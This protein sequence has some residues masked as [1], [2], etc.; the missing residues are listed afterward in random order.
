MKKFKFTLEKY[1]EMKEGEDSTLKRELS[2]VNAQIQQI[3][4]SI[5]EI[6]NREDDH[7]HEYDHKFR[8]GVSGWQLHEYSQYMGYLRQSKLDYID[9]LN[10]LMEKSDKY[11]ER[12]IVLT[13]EIKALNRMKKEQLQAYWKEI[14]EDEAR[15]IDDFVSFKAFSAL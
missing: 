13:N 10:N 7:R 5:T 15:Q 3:N 8:E 2:D 11:K 9:K 1:L 4:A 14:E 6:E 12:L